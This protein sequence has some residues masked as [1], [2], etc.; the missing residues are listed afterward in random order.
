MITAT[1]SM[2]SKAELKVTVHD[3]VEHSNS[4]IYCNEYEIEGEAVKHLMLFIVDTY[5]RRNFIASVFPS[6]IVLADKDPVE[7]K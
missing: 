3:D 6:K 4:F 5:G 2:F 7:V 1:I